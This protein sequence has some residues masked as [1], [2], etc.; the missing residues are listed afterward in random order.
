M[1]EEKKRKI[2]ELE[3]NT[4]KKKELRKPNNFPIRIR[5]HIN[6]LN[7]IILDWYLF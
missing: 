3:E 5:P 1:E 6:P 4:N 2:D 7:D